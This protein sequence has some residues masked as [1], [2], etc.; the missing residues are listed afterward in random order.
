MIEI[1][2]NMWEL[3]HFAKDAICI[4]MACG[5]SKMG[6]AIMGVGMAK[7]VGLYDPAVAAWYGDLCQRTKGKPPVVQRRC[8]GPKGQHWNIIFVPTKSIGRKLPHLCWQNPA[9]VER[10]E[11]S[12]KE[13]S[14][15]KPPNPK[16]RIL[17]PLLGA[18]WGRL[19]RSV[20]R[21]LMDE[22]LTEPHFVRVRK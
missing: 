16:G 10:I 14:E 4:S 22:Y 15:F 5:W 2:G 20:V 17:V 3:A 6:E 18:G 12:L 21:P 7:S 11:R 8:K 19:S 1:K 9:T 13:L